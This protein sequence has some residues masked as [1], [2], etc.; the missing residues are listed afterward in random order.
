[1]EEKK[2]TNLI[3]SFVLSFSIISVVIVEHAILIEI[4]FLNIVTN[5]MK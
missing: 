4:L 3:E 2:N 1:M 5:R